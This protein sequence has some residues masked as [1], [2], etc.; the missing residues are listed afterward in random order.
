VVEFL[1]T[2]LS[3]YLTGALIPID[4]GLARGGDDSAIHVQRVRSTAGPSKSMICISP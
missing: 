3:D 1:A 4:G 2:D